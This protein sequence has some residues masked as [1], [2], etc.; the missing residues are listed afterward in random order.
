MKSIFKKVNKFNKKDKQSFNLLFVNPSKKSINGLLSFFDKIENHTFINIIIN[1][2]DDNEKLSTL[3]SDNQSNIKYSF[4]SKNEDFILNNLLLEVEDDTLKIKYKNN[5]SL[6]EKENLNNSKTPILLLNLKKLKTILLTSTGN[7]QV[8]GTVTETI[9]NR[10]TGSIYIANSTCDKVKSQSEGNIII[11]NLNS[12]FLDITS[13]SKGNITIKNGEITTLNCYSYN[14]GNISIFSK[15][16]ILNTEN[17]GEGCQ[18]FNNILYNSDVILNGSGDIYLMGQSSKYSKVKNN[19]V[20]KITFKNIN[21][22]SCTLFST[23]IGN[24]EISGLTENLHIISS[25]NGNIKGS[26]LK[27]IHSK[28]YNIGLG[29][30][31][32]SPIKTVEIEQHGK[33]DLFMSGQAILDNAKVSINQTGN[34]EGKNIQIKE[35]NYKNYGNGKLIFKKNQSNDLS[36]LNNKNL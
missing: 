26:L 11:E 15:I 8:H 18:K 22:H 31:N 32:I 28:I 10:G 23:D 5:V 4:Y 1:K 29:Y 33:G 25:G 30:I 35:L 13:Y 20:G 2:S 9:I 14:L 3:D 36:G 16:E 24:I 6:L 34:V 19:G 21:T 12:N 7:I 27:A 17:N